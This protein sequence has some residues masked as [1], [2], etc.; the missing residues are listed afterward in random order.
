MCDI[1]YMEIAHVSPARADMQ[2][3]EGVLA[4][5][6]LL[7]EQRLVGVKTSRPQAHDARASRQRTPQGARKQCWPHNDD[8]TLL[9]KK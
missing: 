3:W 5:R 7:T 2:A 8:P 9:K 1:L 4:C 6:L